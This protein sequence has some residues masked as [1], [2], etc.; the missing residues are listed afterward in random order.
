MFEKAVAPLAD[1]MAVTIYFGRD[2]EVGWVIV[3]SRT[4]D[5]PT[6]KHQGL[7]CGTG[8]EQGFQAFPCLR[9]Q[10]H[11]ACDRHWQASLLQGEKP[12]VNGLPE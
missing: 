5:Q 10:N 2:L 7:G 8:T 4:Q 11:R 6:T 3:V 12:S 9:C 1:G